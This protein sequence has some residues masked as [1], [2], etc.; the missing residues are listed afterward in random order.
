[1]ET[2]IFGAGCFWG[3][4]YYFDQVPGVVET[5]IG[6]IGG[7]TDS[8]TYE[9][10]CSYTTGHVEATKITYD[11]KKVSYETL[12]KHFFRIHDP[13]QLNRQ[14]PDVG[15]QYRSTIF[16]LNDEQK[17]QVQKMLDLLSN[18]KKYGNPIVT[19]LEKAT[20][21]WPAEDYH[22]KY[23]EKTGLGACH[24]NYAPV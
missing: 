17:S 8:P 6:Y 23:T 9:Q 1:M 10:V 3:V 13:T 2:A 16:Y 22:Q 20:K 21:F 24:V 4:Q 15:D 7:K 18:S 12:L 11:P 19:S 14:G 5:D